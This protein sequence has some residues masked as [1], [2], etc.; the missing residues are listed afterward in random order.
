MFHPAGAGAFRF[1][2]C[3]Y[4]PRQFS[5]ERQTEEL[6]DTQ[7][8]RRYGR[9]E[10]K[11]ANEVD[12]VSEVREVKRRMGETRGPGEGAVDISRPMLP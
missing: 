2:N 8:G 5:Q 6:Q 9:W 10:M 11:E 3:W 7:I 1:G 4:T 12:E